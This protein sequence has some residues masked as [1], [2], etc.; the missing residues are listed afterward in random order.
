MFTTIHI[1]YILDKFFSVVKAKT[2][3]TNCSPY[4]KAR[5]SNIVLL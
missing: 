5:K 3:K 2:V 1:S 4:K